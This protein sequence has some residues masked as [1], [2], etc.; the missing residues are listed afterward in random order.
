MITRLILSIVIFSTCLTTALHSQE[1]YTTPILKINQEKYIADALNHLLKKKPELKADNLALLVMRYTYQRMPATRSVC[2][3]NG[4]KIVPA[5]PLQEE[6]QVTFKVIDSKH[7]MASKDS[8]KV[9][10]ETKTYDV[11]FPTERMPQWHIGEGSASEERTKEPK[12]K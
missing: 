4:C 1:A 7:E 9:I 2:G 10:I 8:N 11:D 6:L 12:E 5:A 3:P